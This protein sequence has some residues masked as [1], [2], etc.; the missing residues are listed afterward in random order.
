MRTPL[1]KNHLFIAIIVV[2]S[3]SIFAYADNVAPLGPLAR[4]VATHP[5]WQIVM[6][7]PDNNQRISVD[8]NQNGIIDNAENANEA[9]TVHC[10]TDNATDYVSARDCID[11]VLV[12]QAP[13][14]QACL[15]LEDTG[16]LAT[17]NT[18]IPI[19]VNESCMDNICSLRM[20]TYNSKGR[21]GTV[22]LIQ[23]NQRSDNNYFVSLG[24]T[25]SQGVNGDNKNVRL[26]TGS[27]GVTWLNDD[28]F[29]RA[30]STINC[31]LGSNTFCLYV[32]KGYS[33]KIYYCP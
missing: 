32:S 5:L 26:L 31:G 30:T 27:N 12:E 33:V 6:G 9:E 11:R 4:N 8:A 29:V 10:D 16:T 7:T 24:S 22:G 28:Y 17:V 18:R 2:L 19:P 3:I 20:E 14:S 1:W 15:L 13:P 23:Y 21:Y 25:N